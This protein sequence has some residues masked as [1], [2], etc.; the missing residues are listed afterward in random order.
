MLT[1]VPWADRLIPPEYLGN[2]PDYTYWSGSLLPE[3]SLF[4]REYRTPLG[5]KGETGRAMRDQR[6]VSQESEPS[7]VPAEIY[8]TRG[9]NTVSAMKNGTAIK[10]PK[11]TRDALIA[12]IQNGFSTGGMRRSVPWLQIWCPASSGTGSVRYFLTRYCQLVPVQ[13]RDVNLGSVDPDVIQK[14]GSVFL[15]GTSA[16]I[17]IAFSSIP[18][19]ETP[20]CSDVAAYRRRSSSSS[21]SVT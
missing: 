17:A 20:L 14:R 5:E 1:V 19:P 4:L 3:S 16:G 13:G 9:M 15:H 6:E 18:G 12:A 8:H 10:H 21:A 11:E 2:R 7:G